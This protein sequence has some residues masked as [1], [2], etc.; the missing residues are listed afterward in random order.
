MEENNMG[1]RWFM[2]MCPKMYWRPHK[3][4]FRQ[5]FHRSYIKTGTGFKYYRLY[6]F[7]FLG[8]KFIYEVR[9]C[10]H[11]LKRPQSIVKCWPFSLLW[12]WI[13]NK[14][15]QIAL[16]QISKSKQTLRFFAIC[17]EKCKAFVITNSMFRKK[18]A[19]GW[20]WQ[21]LTSFLQ[22]WGHGGNI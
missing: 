3:F 20:N 18:A 6:C 17:I 7:F 4:E 5:A 8:N 10:H 14:T 15:S 9:F 19:K 2:I 21:T 1:K 16:K 11:V 12:S 13:N 22:L